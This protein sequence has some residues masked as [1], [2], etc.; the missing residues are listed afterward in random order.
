MDRRLHLSIVIP[1]HNEEKIIEGRILNLIKQLKNTKYHFQILIVENGS[2]DKT[3]SVCKKISAIPNIKILSLKNANYGKAL[4]TGML[5]SRGKMIINF[6]LDYYDVNFAYQAMALEPFGYDIIIASKN[7][8]SSLDKRSLVRKLIS[9][10]YK[11]LLYYGFGLKVSDTHGIKA[12]RNDDKLHKLIL[13]TINNNEI[14]DTELIIRS[15]YAGRTLLELPTIV[16]E[17]RKPVT[18]ILIRSIRGFYQISKLWLTLKVKER[19]L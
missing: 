4:R 15:Q 1:V 18:S 5:E 14:F 13:S 7:L 10:T 19:W 8:R 2:T 17:M 16:E 12:W 9:S 6:D 11:Y 3:L